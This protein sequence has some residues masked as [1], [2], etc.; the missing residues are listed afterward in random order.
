[1]SGGPKF[2]NKFNTQGPSNPPTVGKFKAFKRRSRYFYPSRYYKIYGEEEGS[3]Q[4]IR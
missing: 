2:D 4:E 1:M 3:R